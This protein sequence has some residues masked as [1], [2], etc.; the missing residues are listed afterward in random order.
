MDLRDLDRRV[1]AQTGGLVAA[2]TAD[3]LD[4]PTPCAGW[5]LRDLLVH[6]VANNH[7]WAEAARGGPSRREV[8][9]EAPLG[10]DPYRAY[11]ES[12]TA[13]NAAFAAA[14][15]LERKFDVYGYG[16]FPARFALGMHF[17][18]YLVHGWD[19]ARSL[20]VAAVFDDELSTAAMRIALRWPY[21][22]PDKAFGVKVDVSDR[23]PA[24]DR[25]VG[26]LGRSPGW[27]N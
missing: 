7:G 10:D 12:A 24:H 11:L 15:L 14:D 21:H 25:L 17:V 4:L 5:S 2:V 22:R 6:M 27:P 1:L 20:G 9:E 18:D 3:Q 19:V 8:W 16:V 23:A 26:Y 13:V